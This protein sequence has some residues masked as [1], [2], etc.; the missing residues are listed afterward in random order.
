MS[1]NSLFKTALAILGFG[2]DT[3]TVA[4]GTVGTAGNVAADLQTY[5]AAQLLE[6]AEFNTILDQFGDKTP[7]PSNS[8]KTI[9]FT[10]M[11]KFTV[12]QTPTQ[13][14]EGI[15]PD[16]Q[17]ITMNQFEAVA[18]QYG[19]LVRLSDLAELTAKH[20]V[21]QKAMY[22]LSL[23]AAET[24][25]QLVF[26]VLN[27]ATNTYY[28]NGKTGD[29]ALTATDVIGYVDLT[30]ID[31]I[32]NDL[33]ARPMDGGDF[34]LVTASQVYASLLNDP[35]YKAAHQLVNP[36]KIYRGEVDTLAGLRVVRSNAPAFG[37]TNQ[38][39]NTG[40]SNKIYT[41]FVF[42]KNAYQISDLQNLK[43]YMVAPGG[44][45]DPLQQNRKLGYKFAFKT[46]ITNQNWLL[47]VRSSGASSVNN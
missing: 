13:L 2:A 42:A 29:A 37:A 1:F 7:I 9:H 33:G 20:P 8:S 39:G 35:S 15:P 12:S 31:A 10:R 6:V 18:E 36:E 3:I 23:Q 5:F 41:S 16:A 21:V 45:S 22:L 26:N 28:P 27:Q 43:V 19:F 14:T 11:E 30:K 47:R 4:T 40:F 38:T 32:L 46:L 44:Q 17:G 24:Y 34:V 25:D